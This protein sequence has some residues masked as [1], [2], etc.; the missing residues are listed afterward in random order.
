M[1]RIH[2]ILITLLIVSLPLDTQAKTKLQIALEAAQKQYAPDKRTAIWDVS[3]TKQNGV[4]T[5]TGTVGTQAQKDLLDETLKPFKATNNVVVLENTLP[6]DKRWA[7]IKLAVASLRCDPKHSAEMATQCG[8]G[9]PVK[10][11]QIVDDWVRVQMPDDYIAYVPESSITYLTAE[12]FATWRQSRRVIVNTYATRLVDQ[13]DGDAT[14]S[15]LTLSNILQVRSENGK[16]VAVTTPDGREGYVLRAEVTDI[17][18]W[19][20]QSFNANLLE[21]TARRMLGSG[22]LWGGTSTKATD[23]S[24]LMKVCYLANGIILQRDAS[25]QALTGQKIAD[26]HQAKL[27]DLLFFGNSKTGRV[28]HV[29]MYLRNGEYIHCSGQV[30]INSLEPGNAS[31]LYSPLSVSR[32]DGQ[33]GTTGITYARNHPWYF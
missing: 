30:K 17:K 11:I 1:N 31:Y 9:T 18:Q 12:Q 23:C 20:E 29:G 15:D 25:Q 22:Y 5:V 3:T 4:T 16:W 28:T 27:G 26:W 2:L 19:S 14:V 32:I 21:T 8:M 33:I 13:P 7:L 10:G 6:C 24:G